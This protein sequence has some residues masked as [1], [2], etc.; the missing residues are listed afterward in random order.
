M[1]EIEFADL[2][3]KKWMYTDIWAYQEVGNASFSENFACL[4]NGWS[5]VQDGHLFCGYL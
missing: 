1:Y 5:L 4:L 3:K 2:K